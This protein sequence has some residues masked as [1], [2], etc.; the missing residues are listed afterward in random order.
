VGN[1]DE[2]M[3]LNLDKEVKAHKLRRRRRREKKRER[4]E[5]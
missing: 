3:E 2:T 4:E 1:N 5:E